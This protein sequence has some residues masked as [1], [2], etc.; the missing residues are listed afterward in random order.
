MFTLLIT[1]WV[2]ANII[3]ICRGVYVM[4]K[5]LTVL[6]LIGSIFLG[7]FTA[8][9]FPFGVLLVLWGIAS[10]GIFQVTLFKKKS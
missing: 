3:S 9:A 2:L 7:C 5:Q 1:L 10:T 8:I 6:Q 4:D